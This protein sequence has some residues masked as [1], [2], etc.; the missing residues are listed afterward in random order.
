[1]NDTHNIVYI[2]WD[3]EYV[4]DKV[5][6]REYYD[7]Q[8]DPWQK[9][10]LWN[11]TTADVQGSLHAELVNLFTCAGSRT[12]LS[13]CHARSASPLLP[14][15]PAP[16]PVPPG[17]SPK[18]HKGCQG[19]PTGVVLNNTDIGGADLIRPCPQT[20]F[21]GTYEGALQCQAAC[22]ANTKCVAWTF[23]LK[24]REK[25]WRCCQKDSVPGCQG[26][27]NMWSGL[28]KNATLAG[29]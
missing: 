9:K 26:A 21:P 22:A 19:E 11:S 24:G 15:A 3:K 16:P 20:T 18:P 14:P 7:L 28:K 4:F 25:K 10:N 13:N 1:M 17:P 23:H 8:A 6:F 12:E 27:K 29:N 2:E 5:D